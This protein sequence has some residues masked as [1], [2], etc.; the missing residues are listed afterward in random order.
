VAKA[1]RAVDLKLIM[2]FS[3]LLC[4]DLWFEGAEP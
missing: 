2:V 4:L 1:N 3:H